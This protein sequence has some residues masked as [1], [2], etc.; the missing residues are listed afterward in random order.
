M[1]DHSGCHRLCL[2]SGPS[3]A[4][5]S[6]RTLGCDR[7]VLPVSSQSLCSVTDHCFLGDGGCTHLRSNLGAWHVSEAENEVDI[8]ARL[9]D[10]N[11]HSRISFVEDS[12]WI[13]STKEM[14]R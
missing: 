9:D 4:A 13:H 1:D 3:A 11:I 12:S 8:N 14:I 2:S 7:W 10:S 6:I 5:R